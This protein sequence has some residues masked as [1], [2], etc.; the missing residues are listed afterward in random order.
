MYAILVYILYLL[1][2]GICDHLRWLSR[3]MVSLELTFDAF[4]RIVIVSPLV[5]PSPS[6]WMVCI[7]GVGAVYEYP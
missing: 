6:C 1:G 2:I 3:E 7:E 4:R 5:I